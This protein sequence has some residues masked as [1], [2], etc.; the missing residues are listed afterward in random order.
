[1]RQEFDSL[2]GQINSQ[3]LYDKELTVKILTLEWLY[4]VS[5][6]LTNKEGEPLTIGT[7]DAKLKQAENYMNTVPQ[8]QQPQILKNLKN[9]SLYQRL[10][11]EVEQARTCIE[12]A[13]AN[14]TLMKGLAGRYLQESVKQAFN[15]SYAFRSKAS[16]AKVEKMLDSA[17]RSKIDLTDEVRYL[18]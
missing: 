1:M 16:K 6:M 3:P 11:W 9:H 12:F 15:V 2:K 14:R 4:S 7:W 10:L 8:A 5:D 18:S 17:K 13:G